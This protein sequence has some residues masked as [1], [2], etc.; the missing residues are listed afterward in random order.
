[1]RTADRRIVDTLTCYQEIAEGYDQLGEFKIVARAEEKV[2]LSLVGDAKTH[3]ILDVG[4]GTGRY[5]KLLEDLGAHRVG[6]DISEKM[7]HTAKKDQNR[8]RLLHRC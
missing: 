5:A 2:L 6:V 4:C 3:R 8:N 1:M 7:I